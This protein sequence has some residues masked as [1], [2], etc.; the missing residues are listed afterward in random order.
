MEGHTPH[1]HA[2]TV[3]SGRGQPSQLGGQGGARRCDAEALL[4]HK[5]FRYL[6]TVVKDGGAI[7]GRAAPSDGNGCRRD[8][9]G[10]K[11]GWCTGGSGWGGN[12]CSLG[13]LAFLKRSINNKQLPISDIWP[14]RG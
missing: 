9:T 8:D 12:G 2:Y 7:A 11:G 4:A 1:Q 5:A 13:R 3:H 10:A 6:N 14:I